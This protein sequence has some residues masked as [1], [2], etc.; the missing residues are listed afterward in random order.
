VGLKLSGRRNLDRV[1]LLVSMD[2]YSFS[3]YKD[4]VKPLIQYRTTF[5]GFVLGFPISIGYK[6]IKTPTVSFELSAGASGL[7]LLDNKE[8]QNIGNVLFPG[9]DFQIDDSG[10]FS[11][12]ALGEAAVVWKEKWSVFSSIPFS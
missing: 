10:V 5:S 2:G 6:L 8:K 11:F 1:F 12:S 7:I 4:F 3:N 9:S